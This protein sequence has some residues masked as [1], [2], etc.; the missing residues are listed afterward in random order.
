M[1]QSTYPVGV[2]EAAVVVAQD[3]LDFLA[4]PA[5]K[6]VALRTQRAR[7]VG[8]GLMRWAE[9]VPWRLASAQRGCWAGAGT[10]HY[11]APC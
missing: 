10:P 3:K 4:A 5:A 6:V 8:R 7:Q 1:P 9:R 11:L 2:L